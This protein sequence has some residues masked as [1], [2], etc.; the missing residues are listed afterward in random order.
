MKFI[1][2][3]SI[4]LRRRSAIC[5]T[6]N[7]KRE[8]TDTER[9]MLVA[10][11]KNIESLGFRFSKSAMSRM[12]HLDRWEIR[13]LYEWIVPELKKIVGADVVYEPMY[14][15]FP[16]Q[17]AETEETELYINALV[18]YLTFGYLLPEYEKDERIPLFENLALREIDV[19]EYSEILNVFSNLVGSKTSLSQQDKEDIEV[20]VSEVL[21]YENF[22]PDEIPYKENVALIGKIIIEKSKFDI[23]VMRLS[24]YFK[25]ATDVLRLVV[26]LSDGDISLA[27]PTRFKKLNRKERR[28]VMSLL[29]NCEGDITED[30]YGYRNEWLRIGEIIHPGEFK[31]AGKYETAT[32]AFD[33][34][35]NE[36][37]PLGWGGKV[38]Y[39]VISGRTKDAVLLLSKRPGEFA[40]H[41]DKLL[42]DAAS[43]DDQEFVCNEFKKVAD[44]V[45]TRVLLQVKSHF[46]S[47]NMDSKGRVFFPK[48]N[49]AKAVVVDNNLTKISTKI[50]ANV[51]SICTIALIKNY[52]EREKM[53]RVWIDPDFQNCVCPFSQRS[54][55]KGAA[56]TRGSRIPMSG[57]TIRGFIWWTNTNND[58]HSG[59]YY[60]NGRVDLDLSAVVYD[61]EWDYVEHVSYT[62][63]RSEH[64]FH[65]GDIVNGGRLDG[66]GVAEFLDFEP[67][68]VGKIG[69]Y[70]V[71]QVFSFTRQP[72]A[73]IPNCRFGF[74]EREFPNSGEIF[75][76]STVKERFDLTSDSVVSIPVIFDCEKMEFIWCDMTFD[77]DERR[78]N[79]LEN[80]L[81]GT[82][83]TCYAVERAKYEKPNLY[84]LILL[85]ALAR[86]ELAK[87]R[88]EADIVFSNESVDGET[89]PV[90][91]S[92]CTDYFMNML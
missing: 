38:H 56:L 47:R 43:E 2:I 88:E 11:M 52:S 60:G 10:V 20:I 1:K 27:N 35:R 54:A 4:L 69:R 7:E 64:I 31:E 39:A 50:C 87:T 48:G 72:F 62:R 12:I 41:L 13:D 71:F 37:K 78:S 30:M 76:P 68:E 70:L 8:Q 80:N 81:H 21:D 83:A 23:P 26:A 79:N 74:M 40:R 32:A 61:D 9:R 89:V 57:N 82:G 19:V 15:N 55:S 44:K 29:E 16:Q 65:S 14:P 86:G 3:D 63:L 6:V 25:T 49:I 67:K 59:R 91:T 22:L 42:R 34:I 90:I 28:A 46:E 18:H 33:K 53:G 92:L 58:D 73:S 66:S 51:V 45:S 75:E 17:V 36:K 24:Q 77:S 84:T 85:N 5:L